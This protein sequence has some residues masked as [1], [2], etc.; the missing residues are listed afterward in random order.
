MEKGGEGEGKGALQIRGQRNK[1]PPLSLHLGKKDAKERKASLLPFLIVFRGRKRVLIYGGSRIG[2]FVFIFSQPGKG[3]KK[4]EPGGGK[5]KRW[6]TIRFLPY[7]LPLE[8]GKKKKTKKRPG[9]GGTHKEKI[10][11]SLSI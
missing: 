9:G 8:V 7:Q 11:P 4:G 1:P 5:G 2:K 3:G 6:Q 10:F